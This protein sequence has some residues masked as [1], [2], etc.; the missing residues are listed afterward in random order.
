VIATLIASSNS[1]SIT[2]DLNRLNQEHRHHSQEQ[3]VFNAY[4]SIIDDQKANANKLL[5]ETEEIYESKISALRSEFESKL[6][7]IQDELETQRS[8]KT[9]LTSSGKSSVTSECSLTYARQ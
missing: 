5:A 6:K 9:S 7:S 1:N 8:G 3:A 2:Q 4:Q